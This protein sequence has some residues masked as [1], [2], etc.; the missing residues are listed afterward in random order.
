MK[1]KQNKTGFKNGAPAIKR[2]GKT[3]IKIRSLKNE[4]KILHIHLSHILTE[5]DVN[6]AH[7]VD[8]FNIALVSFVW[9]FLNQR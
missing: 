3:V 6:A 2:L 9:S 1:K 4:C 7:Q 5:L 8:R